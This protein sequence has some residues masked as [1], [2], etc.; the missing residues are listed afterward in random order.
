[1][2][3][4]SWDLISTSVNLCNSLYCFFIALTVILVL[5]CTTMFVLFTQGPQQLLNFLNEDVAACT[6]SVLSKSSSG[7]I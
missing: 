4:V 2:P 3:P 7:W 1:M 6:F 5:S